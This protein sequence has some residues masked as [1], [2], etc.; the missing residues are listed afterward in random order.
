MP[1]AM[2]CDRNKARLTAHAILPMGGKIGP[3]YEKIGKSLFHAMAWHESLLFVVGR[4][5]FL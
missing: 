1:G 3:L 2:R 5:I 4:L